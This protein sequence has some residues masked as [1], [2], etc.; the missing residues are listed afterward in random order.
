MTVISNPI[1]IHRYMG[2]STDTKPTIAAPLGLAPP[3]KA[4]T[5]YEYDTGTLWIT[6]DGTNWVPKDIGSKRA[7]T[8]GEP[9]LRGSANGQATWSRWHHQMGT[10]G[11]SAQLY[12]GIQSSFNDWARVMIPVNDMPIKDLKS[13]LWGWNNTEEEVDGLAMQV[14][15]R[16]DTDPDLIVNITQKG[17]GVAVG[18][19]WQNHTLDLDAINWF[20][21]GED[22]D[23]GSGL[24]EG[25]PNYYTFGEFQDD[26]LFG[27]WVIYRID[28]YWGAATGNAE[29]KNLWLTDVRINGQIIPLK[30]DSSGT[31]RFGTKTYTGTDATVTTGEAILAPKTPYRL[32]S[33]SNK[34]NDVQGG[35][36]SFV[37]NLL[38]EAGTAYDAT[39]LTDDM[40]VPV[41]RKSLYAAFGQG[42]EFG[43][44][45]ELDILYTNTTGKTFGIVY[46]YEVLV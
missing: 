11:W 43:M 44:D 20:W 16:S 1:S 32:L 14:H 9:T 45:D 40:Y 15:I 35:A 23:G 31:G 27:S 34:I 42:Y 12:G 29:Y 46:R 8:F 13:V 24:D 33:I 22:G 41:T 39:L 30:P 3:T 28:F 10:T 36:S 19:G 7:W 25:L 4:S 26:A 37:V 2:L 18:A 38:S 17:T 5:F 6:Y 21:Y